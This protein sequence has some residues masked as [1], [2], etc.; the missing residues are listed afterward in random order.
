[1]FVRVGLSIGLPLAALAFTDK[2][3]REVWAK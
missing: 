1:V 3:F 2:D